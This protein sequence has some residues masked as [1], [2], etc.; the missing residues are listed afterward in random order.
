MINQM[1]NQ[2]DVTESN[3]DRRSVAKKN[4]S[5]YF[6]SHIESIQDRGVEA[7]IRELHGV[8]R[9][10]HE[11][12]GQFPESKFIILV[13]DRSEHLLN[14]HGKFHFV[15]I[16]QLRGACLERLDKLRQEFIS[17]DIAKSKNFGVEFE[18]KCFERFVYLQ[19]IAES[20]QID[21]IY[22]IDIDLALSRDLVARLIEL[23]DLNSDVPHTVISPSSYGTYLSGFELDGIKLF[24][25]FILDDYFEDPASKAYRI[26][27][28]GAFLECVTRGYLGC[29]SSLF[30]EYS[31]YM[32][33]LETV[34]CSFH[35]I[36]G[37]V[38]LELGMP[39]ESVWRQPDRDIIQA[40]ANS[41]K[42]FQMHPDLTITLDDK[43]VPF[44]HFHGW[45]K[46]FAPLIIDKGRQ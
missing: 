14:Q 23:E 34:L 29:D 44:I 39:L 30:L 2:G 15:N 10:N 35:H 9:W 25:D 37:A 1:V 20:H 43:Q 6:V 5:I 42:F 24:V 31:D 28:M 21:R 36:T 4:R 33:R 8:L 46:R 45:S 18:L 27:D 13:N 11:V 26:S 32:R 41:K 17:I 40:I 12:V 3:G 38:A 7:V 22:H 16:S 19:A